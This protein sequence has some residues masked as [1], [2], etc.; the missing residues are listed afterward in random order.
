M[1][2]ERTTLTQDKVARL[3]D[4]ATVD[5]TVSKL[6]ELIND[7][8]PNLEEIV[9]VVNHDP[10]ITTVI[11]RQ[12]NS[13]AYG[14]PRVIESV[15]HAIKLL[16]FRR[17]RGLVLSF[18]V[19]RSV[20]EVEKQ[21]WLHSYSTSVL[22]AGLIDMND[23]S[24]TRD[25]AITALLHDVGRLAMR[26]I[27][28]TLYNHTHHMSTNEN[29]PITDAE[30]Y[31]FSVSHD[32]VGDWLLQSWNL[33]NSMRL[34]VAFHHQ[35]AVPDDMQLES[36]LLQIVDYIDLKARGSLCHEPSPALMDAAG[37]DTSTFDELEEYQKMK[38]PELDSSGIFAWPAQLGSATVRLKQLKSSKDLFANNSNA[39]C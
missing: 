27:D 2:E 15:E 8:E 29:I 19:L 20:A 14:L 33:P 17:L 11:L 16:G 31:Y 4:L 28:E 30:R 32:T 25:I 9:D 35:D 10:A 7:P 23:L 26:Q 6:M 37:V 38:Y 34:P 22:M 24:V 1:T 5:S 39:S 18:S 36:A 21:I 3:S 13:A 12:I